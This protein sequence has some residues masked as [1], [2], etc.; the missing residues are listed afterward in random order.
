MGVKLDEDTRERLK[1]LADARRRSAHWLMKEAISQY[2][3]REEEIEQRNREADEAWQDYQRT[4]LHV[5]HEAMEAW[6]DSWGT[7]KEGPCPDLES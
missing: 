3:A 1:T 6:L 5:S 7:D 2:L 4:G